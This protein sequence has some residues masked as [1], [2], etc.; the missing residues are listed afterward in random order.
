MNN[1]PPHRRITLAV[2]AIVAAAFWLSLIAYLTG[3]FATEE[4]TVASA[5]EPLMVSKYDDRIIQ[6]Q[7]DAADN[8]YRTQ[9]EYLF[10]IWMKDATGQPERAAVGARKARNAYIDVMKAIDKNE[11]DL[12]KLRQLIPQN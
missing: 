6:L 7:R 9:I 5:D 12:L 4:Y 3:Y 8:A 1:L 11:A 10:A 2:V